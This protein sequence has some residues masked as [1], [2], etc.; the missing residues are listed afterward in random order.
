MVPTSADGKGPRTALAIGL[1]LLLVAGLGTGGW[2]LWGRG[3][4]DPARHSRPPAKAVDAKLDWM[5]PVPDAD[6]GS[7]DEI[8][9]PWFTDKNVIVRSSKAVTAYSIATG[10]PGWTLPVPG[11]ACTSSP[12][13]E[14][15]IAAVVYGKEEFACDLVMAVDLEHGRM[16]WTKELTD[17]KGRKDSHHTANISLVQGTL[18]LADGVEPR[19]YNARTGERLTPHDYG[20][21]TAGS[22]AGPSGAEQLTVAQCGIYGRSF[23]MS[24][25]PKTGQEKWTWKLLDGLEAHNILSVDPAVVT[26]AR[27]DDSDP[28]DVVVLDDNGRLRSL[29]SA[30]AGPYEFGDCTRRLDSCRSTVVDGDTLYLATI[31][32][33]KETD[34]VYA[35]AIAAIDLATGKP[36]WTTALA[37]NRRYRPVTMHEGRL[38]VYQ[39]A[40]KD[41]AGKLLSLDPDN[42]SS[43]VFMNLPQESADEEYKIGRLGTVYFRNGRFYVVSQIGMTDRTMMMSFH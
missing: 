14:N 23:V 43:A 24:V 12:Q 20:C 26:V 1:G 9:R 5:A 15:G 16:L 2:F 25:D 40:S 30:S 39:E 6:K 36:R 18:T 33:K 22:V 8:A 31:N 4:N 34:G 27:K 38:L 3:G 11:F 7:A 28:T 37:G 35:N 29:I 10:K 13:Q 21:R 42:G 32:G 41:E 19:V 17:S